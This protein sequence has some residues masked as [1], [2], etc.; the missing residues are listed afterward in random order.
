MSKIYLPFYSD[1]ALSLIN[2]FNV[3]IKNN[4]LLYGLSGHILY[5]ASEPNGQII[6]KGETD[7]DDVSMYNKFSCISKRF[8]KRNEVGT[9]KWV[10]MNIGELFKMFYDWHT[11]AEMKKMSICQN[12]PE[13]LEES[14]IVEMK[15]WFMDPGII[16]KSRKLIGIPY[17]PIKSEAI[18]NI[19]NEMVEN[20][21]KTLPEGRWTYNYE[22]EN[23][24]S[25]IRRKYSDMMHD[26]TNRKLIYFWENVNDDRVRTYLEIG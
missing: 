6:I 25:K 21:K 17:D 16:V 3:W 12:F 4:W 7:I 11:I 26:L 5:V 8:K 24:R 1:Q 23:E 20:I 10:M 2:K 15:H 14:D 22:A 13:P 9:K 18:N 19:I